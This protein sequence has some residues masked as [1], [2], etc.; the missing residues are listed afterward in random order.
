MSELLEVG[1]VFSDRGE[2]I[3]GLDAPELVGWR[4]RLGGR[5]VAPP[6]Q[7]ARVTRIQDYEAGGT[8]GGVRFKLVFLE[9]DFGDGEW[10]PQDSPQLFERDDLPDLRQFDRAYEYALR[11]KAAAGFGEPGFWSDPHERKY[12][13]DG[14]PPLSATAVADVRT[15]EGMLA[16][17]GKALAALPPG[18]EATRL[19]RLVEG[20]T[21]DAYRFGRRIAEAELHERHEAEAVR[22]A[23]VMAGAKDGG[24]ARKEAARKDAETWYLEFCD[25]MRTELQLRHGPGPHAI[26]WDDLLDLAGEIWPGNRKRPSSRRTLKAALEWGMRQSPPQFEKLP[27]PAGRK[28]SGARK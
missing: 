13:L 11:V 2:P 21:A 17:V 27:A 24:D 12:R 15:L 3:E 19:R 8:V 9:V 22:S 6:G 23:K 16:A 26:S 7:R 28:P 25:L 4:H 10:R 1:D 20:V 18:A 5:L 14:G